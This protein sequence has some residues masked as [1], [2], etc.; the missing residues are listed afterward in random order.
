LFGIGVFNVLVALFYRERFVPGDG[1]LLF[2]G[3]LLVCATITTVAVW[4]R[5]KHIHHGIDL[6]PTAVRWAMHGYFLLWAVFLFIRPDQRLL[7]MDM[8]LFLVIVAL[9]LAA[10]E[11][12]LVLLVTRRKRALS[13]QLIVSPMQEHA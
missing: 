11:I 6:I 3:L 13:K 4:R 7:G 2:A 12:A 10:G 1:L 9:L 8:P 5:R